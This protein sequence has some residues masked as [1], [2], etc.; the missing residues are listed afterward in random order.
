[1]EIKEWIMI[2]SVIVIVTGWFTNS[3]LNRRHEISKKRLDYR[4]ETLQSFLPVFLSMSSSSKPFI[5]NKTL[6][7]KIIYA[8]VNFQIYGY[9]DEWILFNSFTIAI[10]KQDVSEATICINKLTKLIRN[11][12][13]IELKLPNF[14]L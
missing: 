3:Y 9:Q 13:Q 14:D 4:L 12:I 1:M 5:D 11:R 10:D 2:I 8:R 7:D 6:N